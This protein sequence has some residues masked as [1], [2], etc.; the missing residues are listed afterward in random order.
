MKKP[1][2]S[3]IVPTHN[4]FDY[5]REAL[6]S[7]AS[8]T[9]TDYEVIVVDDGS[10]DDTPNRISNHPV[11]PSVVRQSHQGPAA[12][13]NRGIKE[14]SADVVAF[15]DSDDL[16]QPAKLETFMA[17]L[18]AEPDVHVFYGPMR[19]IDAGGKTVPGRTKPCHE[20]RITQQLFCSSFV[21]IPTVVCRK[22]TLQRVN[23]FDSSL[24]VCEDYDLW[25]RVS[26]DEPFGLV[27][28]A[29]A[30]RRLHDNRLSKRL[31]A[32]NLEVKAKVL[33]RFYESNVANGQ[34]DPC[35]AETRLS[36][37]LYVAG[38][39]AFR[40]GRYQRA[41]EL[42]RE[43]RRYGR[44]PLRTVP[45]MVCAGTRSLFSEDKRELQTSP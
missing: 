5:L 41:I 13:R 45:L 24:A 12:A 38:R 10:T 44:S 22:A 31:M 9:Y 25:L 8:Q 11:G 33:Q 3:I 43:S 36:R 20:G 4:R 18:D 34:L 37:I 39:E 16:W 15:L 19:P 17:A 14:A 27:E 40:C 30:L 21:H 26:V 6:D 35:V 1:A 32:R 42:C 7:I 28:E 2:V 29:L 23:G